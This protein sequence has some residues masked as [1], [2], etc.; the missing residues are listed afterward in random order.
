M[1]LIGQTLHER[2]AIATGRPL[3]ERFIRFGRRMPC[4]IECDTVIPQQE[5]D[6]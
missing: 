6:L 2:K 1:Q 5:A 4:R 3:I